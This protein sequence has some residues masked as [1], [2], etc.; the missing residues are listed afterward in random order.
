MESMITISSIS[1]LFILILAI[2]VFW[3]R[4]SVKAV[5]EVSEFEM[6]EN[7]NKGKSEGSAS[8]KSLSYQR[9]EHLVPDDWD[10]IVQFA[11]Q[12]IENAEVLNFGFDVLCIEDLLP[13]S[14]YDRIIKFINT[15]HIKVYLEKNP[16]IKEDTTNEV[17]YDLYQ[18]LTTR[19]TTSNF[20][21]CLQYIML[22]VNEAINE[23]LVIREVPK[24]S[25]SQ[26]AHLLIRMKNDFSIDTHVHP[27]RELTNGLLYLPKTDSDAE[28]GTVI[29]NSKDGVTIEYDP[30]NYNSYETKD[31]QVVFKAQYIPNTLI[32]WKNN[33]VA[34]HGA[35][36]VSK[37]M[38]EKKRYIFFGTVNKE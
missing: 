11:V 26:F 12:R 2:I 6:E 1:I 37:P 22:N 7:A 13:K 4:V 29:Y 19:D 36:L 16:I 38:S 15:Q 24:T 28:Q 8:A 9:E 31:F 23:K 32:A 25:Q 10:K 30:D 18:K 5:S 33:S 35:D 17:Y 14:F 34:Y 20:L 27:A 3:R 21:S